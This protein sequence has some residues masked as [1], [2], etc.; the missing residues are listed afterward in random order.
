MDKILITVKGDKILLLPWHL[1][2]SVDLNAQF[3]PVFALQDPSN[4]MGHITHKTFRG[5]SVNINY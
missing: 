2:L 5:N 4:V 1:L 3:G